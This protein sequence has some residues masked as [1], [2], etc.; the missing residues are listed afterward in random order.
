MLA[1]YLKIFKDDRKKQNN[2][3]TF[4]NFHIQRADYLFS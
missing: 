4:L 1:S 3:E 2:C